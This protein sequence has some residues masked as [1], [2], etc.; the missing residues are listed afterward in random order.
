MYWFS[1]VVDKSHAEIA[2][3]R[4]VDDCATQDVAPLFQSDAL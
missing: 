3:A 1:F 4:S 2:H